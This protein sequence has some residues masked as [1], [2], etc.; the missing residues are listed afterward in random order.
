MRKFILLIALVSVIA[1]E[2][3]AQKGK[4]KDDRYIDVS[5]GPSLGFRILGNYKVPANY[6]YSAPVY[7][8]SL[9]EVD[10]P[11]QSLNLGVQYMRKKSAFSAFSIGLSYTD[12]TF[13]RQVNNPKIGYEVH[14]KV[15]VLAGVIQAGLLA[16]NYDFHYRYMEVPLM[17]YRSA[18]G[19]GNLRDFDLWYIYGF[20]PAILIQDRILIKT[21]GFTLNGTDR[22]SVKDDDIKGRPFNVMAHVGFRSQYHLYER[23]HGL[24]QPRLRIPLLPVS[25]GTQTMWIPQLSLDVG[26]VF[27]L[28]DDK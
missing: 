15:G 27:M 19:Y 28:S 11:G 22:F 17:W 2:A 16:V 21:E 25:G 7:R 20:A 8:D 14:P 26:L 13:R 23:I 1:P 3:L 18:E 6:R 10:R 9:N 24:F 12:L 5:V 4:K